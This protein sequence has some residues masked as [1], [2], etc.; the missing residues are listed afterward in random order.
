MA[1]ITT[2]TE[3]VETLEPAAQA[4]ARPRPYRV[5]V[6]LY[7]RMIATGLFREKEPI[8][9]WRGELVEKMTKGRRHNLA[10]TELNAAL[11]RIV[12][13]GWLVRPEQPVT[14]P[15]DGMPEPDFTIV[16]G[17][18]RDF[19]DRD[20]TAKDVAL[21]AEVSDSSLAVDSGAM[22]EDYAREEIP[23]YWVVNIPGRTID[24]YTRPTGARELGPPYYAERHSYN[25][26]EDVPVTLDGRE[27]GRIAVKDVL[28]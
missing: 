24:V 2:E 11:V 21:V 4:V 9:L 7:Q 19:M 26:D 15:S 18:S 28:P 10:S 3:V 25:S 20:V 14:L 8:Y 16:R 27:V 13:Q 6:E 5:T 1:T 23:I 17:R 12:P 22:V